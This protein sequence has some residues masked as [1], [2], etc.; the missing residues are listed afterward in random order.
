MAYKKSDLNFSMGE[1]IIE[2]PLIKN[3]IKEDKNENIK[4]VF[5]SENISDNIN[6]SDNY[7]D[8]NINDEIINENFLKLIEDIVIKTINRKNPKNTNIDNRV[9]EQNL[10]IL[11]KKTKIEKSN[12]KPKVYLSE[13]AKKNWIYV[14]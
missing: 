5:K 2:Y 10:K 12:K 9:N 1:D 8:T 6:E 4:Q 11:E 3:D 13:K 14:K 7:N